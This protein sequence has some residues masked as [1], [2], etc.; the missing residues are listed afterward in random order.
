MDE[1]LTVTCCDCHKPVVLLF[2]LLLRLTRK[3][4]K[5]QE[6]GLVTMGRCS[7]CYQKGDKRS[8]RMLDEFAL[9]DFVK[10]VNSGLYIVDM[11][12]E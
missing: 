12:T 2:T 11:E 1:I 6:L 9:A 7:W 8:I 4:T 5:K 3:G 10:A